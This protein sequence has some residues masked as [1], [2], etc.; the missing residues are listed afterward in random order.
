MNKYIE[1]DNYNIKKLIIIHIYNKI[2]ISVII[3]LILILI[4]LIVIYIKI[5]I[6]SYII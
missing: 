6:I 1:K 4:I 3:S 2:I 5:K